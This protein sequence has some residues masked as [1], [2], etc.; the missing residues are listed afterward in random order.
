[1]RDYYEI[2]G[3]SKDAD[4]TTLKK[5]Y[6]SLAMK[7]HPD[8]NPDDK[9][10]AEKFKE[11]SQAYDVLRDSEK[12]SAYDNFGHAAFENGAGG[13]SGFSGF[14]GTGFS[15]IFDDLFGEFTGA[16]RSQASSRSRGSDLRYNMMLSL[17]EAFKGL[18]KTI[19]INA[20]ARCEP[21]DGSGA[22][23]GTSSVASCPNCG[24]NGKVR[25]SQGFFTIERTCGQCS[26]TGK[27]IQ[28]PCKKCSGTGVTRKEKS[29]SVN[30]PPGVDDGT[31]IR[32]SGE[33]RFNF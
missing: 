32:V 12:R 4:N 33:G 24:G 3:V 19:K 13:S 25:A 16:N 27:I 11:A 17:N 15:D 26:G 23:G 6:R 1:M 9:K 31:R 21:C 2:L 28:R 14:Q 20:S 30:I 5:A 18:E 8:R 29:L 22:E 10:A 7:Y